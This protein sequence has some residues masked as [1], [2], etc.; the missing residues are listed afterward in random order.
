VAK[1]LEGLPGRHA[2]NTQA[3][4]DEIFGGKRFTGFEPARANFLEE[5]LMDLE[6]ERDSALAIKIKRVHCPPQLYR[7]L[8]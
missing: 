4:G 5:V 1:R 2:A 8:G 6:V 7:Q 3:F